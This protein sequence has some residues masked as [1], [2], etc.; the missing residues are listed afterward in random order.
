MKSIKFLAQTKAGRVFL[1]V[2]AITTFGFL[3]RAFK[4]SSSPE[5]LYIDETSIGY[6]AYSLVQTGRDEHGKFFP[7]FFEAFGE[8]KLPVYIYLVAL[9]QVF[10]G[11]SDLSVRLP[12]LIL[13]TLT[14]PLVFL[15]IREVV[16]ASKMNGRELIPFLSAFLLAI[17]P[18]H[19]QF[20]RPGFEV[21]VGLFFLTLGLWAFL[22]S[23]RKRSPVSMGISVLAFVFCLYSYNSMRIVVPIVL[24]VL[25]LFEFRKFSFKSWSLFVLTGSILLIP[26]FLFITGE[27]GFER[28]RQVSIFYQDNQND[29]IGIFFR[30]YWDNISPFYL[31]GNGDPTID[32]LTPF[33]MSLLYLVEIPFFFL[34]IVKIL[35]SRSKTFFLMLILLL[36]GTIVPAITILSPHAL[37]G[38]LVLPATV[39]I[40]SLGFVYFL[41]FLKK[42]TYKKLIFSVYLV[43]LLISAFEFLEIYHNKYLPG[44]GWDWQVGIKRT[45]I[46]VKEIEQQYSDVYFDVDPRAIPVAWYLKIAPIIYQ[47]SID[48]KHMGKYHI[49]DV[50]SSSHGLYVGLTPP[51][52]QLIE[53]INYPDNSVAFGIWEF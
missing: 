1:L 5:G 28:A 22:L 26:F 12:S 3:I 53:Y 11:P 29:L 48:K 36:A 27:N 18:W 10:L 7:L 32:H 35:T 44:A 47:S 40:S 25:W 24:G 16:E 6:N 4:I 42:P 45:S 52:G 14:I 50:V 23:V 9:S 38:M 51:Q 30:N 21:T 17:S 49:N 19:F 46:K 43:F 13:G 31:F 39:F 8:Y 37:R 15:L 2:L 20:S 34:G 41:N 33:R